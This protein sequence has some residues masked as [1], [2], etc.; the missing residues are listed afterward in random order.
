MSAK[1]NAQLVRCSGGVDLEALYAVI[2]TGPMLP[3]TGLRTGAQIVL[4]LVRVGVVECW[5]RTPTESKC[6]V[7]A[8]DFGGICNIPLPPAPGAQAA[9]RPDRDHRGLGPS[10]ASGAA[11]LGG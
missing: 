5:R 11:G 8:N 3:V 7:A 10:A 9:Y 6:L 1:N 2:A 4:E